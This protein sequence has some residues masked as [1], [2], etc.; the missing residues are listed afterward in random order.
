V[1]ALGR[2]GLVTR[3]FEQKLVEKRRR[4]RELGTVEAHNFDVVAHLRRRI[5]G[6]FRGLL[7]TLVI[8][9]DAGTLVAEIVGDGYR[10]HEDDLALERLF[11]VIVLRHQTGMGTALM[12]M[13]LL[14]IVLTVRLPVGATRWVAWLVLAGIELMTVCFWFFMV[15][16]AV[17]S[18]TRL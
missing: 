5:A 6:Q 10:K 1:P 15:A 14:R 4:F 12:L 18:T 8:Q 13:H 3:I 9:H 2:D 16:S 7:T 11:T 17:L